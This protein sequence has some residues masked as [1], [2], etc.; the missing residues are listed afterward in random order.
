MIVSEVR[1]GPCLCCL[2]RCCLQMLVAAVPLLV[3]P[4]VLPTLRA[5]M[6]DQLCQGSFPAATCLKEFLG[7]A[8]ATGIDDEG[9][10]SATSLSLLPNASEPR[11]CLSKGTTITSRE[12]WSFGT[13][14]RRTSSC[15]AGMQPPVPD[16][17]CE[18]N[19]VNC[20]KMCR[21]VSF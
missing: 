16:F 17:L 3:L 6:E 20:L 8:S 21:G 2:I 12:I 18:N 5:L 19:Y 13:L 4:E 15:R 11:P 1:R 14:L 7:Y 9:C 10:A